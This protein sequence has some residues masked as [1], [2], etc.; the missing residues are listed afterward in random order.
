MFFT[1]KTIAIIAILATTTATITF[2]GRKVATKATPAPTLC[3]CCRSYS[4][5]CLC[6]CSCCTGV[7]EKRNHS[8]LTHAHPCRF[9]NR[10]LEGRCDASAA[11]MDVAIS[12]HERAMKAGVFERSEFFF[13]DYTTYQ[14]FN[15]QLEIK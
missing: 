14:P 8:Y 7:L 2:I 12:V 4:C 13:F 15:P 3:P 5:S 6:V 9:Q 1:H 11:L 10:A